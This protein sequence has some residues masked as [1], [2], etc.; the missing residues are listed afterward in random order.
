MTIFEERGTFFIP[1]DKI[2]Y[3]Y[4]KYNIFSKHQKCFKATRIVEEV[5]KWSGTSF[6]RTKI[7]FEI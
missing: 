7:N 1:C 2:N 6:E 3:F 5:V 4:L